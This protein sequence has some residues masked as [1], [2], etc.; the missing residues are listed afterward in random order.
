M[1]ASLFIASFFIT[2]LCLEGYISIWYI[3]VYNH[4]NNCDQILENRPCTHVPGFREIQIW[5]FKP[6]M[7][8]MR[9][10]IW[11]I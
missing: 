1:K 7:R 6:N 8:D 10:I 2:Y 3:C 5:N 9:D 11:E 4:N